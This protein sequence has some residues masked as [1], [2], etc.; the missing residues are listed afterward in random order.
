MGNRPPLP[1]VSLLTRKSLQTMNVARNVIPIPL[2]DSFYRVNFLSRNFHAVN[3][4]FP[5]DR[6][7]MQCRARRGLFRTTAQEILKGMFQPR[8]GIDSLLPSIDAFFRLPIIK[9]M[10]GR[11]VRAIIFNV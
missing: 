6:A 4:T 11:S 1:Y 5:F 3:W 7:S 9:L 2:R 10:H 8:Q